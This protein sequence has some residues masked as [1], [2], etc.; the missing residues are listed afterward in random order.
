MGV[1]YYPQGVITP[2]LGL[3]L[4][5]MDEVLA[6]DMIIL[7]AFAGTAQSIQINGSVIPSTNFVDSA[8]VTFTVAGNNVSANA[9]GGGGG[10]SVDVNGV[11]IADPNF[12][13]T[14]PAAP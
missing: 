3:S 1:P 9:V 14:V 4:N 8:T 5:G 11:S 13:N 10:S 2:N 12:N 6:D 7:D